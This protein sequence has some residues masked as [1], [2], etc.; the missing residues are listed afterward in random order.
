MCGVHSCTIFAVCSQQQSQ[1]TVSTWVLRSHVHEHFVGLY[2]KLNDSRIFN[3]QTH[4]QVPSTH[5]DS[6]LMTELTQKIL[7]DHELRDTP[8][9]NHSLSAADNRPSPPGKEF[10]EGSGVLRSEFHTCHTLLAHASSRSPRL[11][12]HWEPLAAG[13]LRCWPIEPH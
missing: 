6:S 1:H 9:E 13:Q 10:G 8:S 12:S 3:L 11:N 2:V 4:R 7:S 5:P